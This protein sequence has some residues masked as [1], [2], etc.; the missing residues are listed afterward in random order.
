MLPEPEAMKSGITRALRAGCTS[1]ALLLPLAGAASSAAEPSSLS[2]ASSVLERAREAACGS[3]NLRALAAK[4]GSVSCGST[5]REDARAHSASLARANARATRFAV[6]RAVDGDGA[7]LGRLRLATIGAVGIDLVA[8]RS[9]GLAVTGLFCFVDDG[10]PRPTILHLHGGFGGIFVNPDGGDTIGTCHRWASL[11]GKNAFVPSY[12]GQDG[13]QGTPELC[14]GEADDVAAAA[15]LL[16]S[17]AVVDSDR[18]ALVGGSMGGCVALRAG[19]SIPNLRAVVAIAPPT[20]WKALVEFHRTNYA[21]QIESRCDGSWTD[22]NQGGPAFADVIDRTICG[23]RICSDAEYLVRSPLLSA[24]N[25]RNP[26]LVLAGGADNLV[27]VAQQVL[28]PIARQAAGA[29]IAV[30]IRD[31]CAAAVTPSL[32]RDGFFFVP[33]G[34]HLLEAGNISSALLY[35]LERLDARADEASA[36]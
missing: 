29:A 3:T 9:S 15:L 36:S 20:D 2:P 18:I 5:S 11:F 17:E 14:L 23:H 8:Y 19:A 10:T 34:F 4:S 1:C 21:A 32:A 12:R 26:T 35:L 6:A 25:A 28:W 27:P 33:G 22:W 16:R 31:R 24:A 13:G 7:L 30:E